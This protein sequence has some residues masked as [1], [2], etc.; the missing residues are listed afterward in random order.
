MST[1][2][3]T[4]L[5]LCF[6]DE[7]R[8]LSVTTS[9]LTFPDL[10]T[11]A[12]SVFPHLTS[13]QFSWVD[14]EGDKV[15]INSSE[16]FDEAVRVMTSENKG[17]LRFEVLAPTS[18]SSAESSEQTQAP[19][20]GA[21]S[22][23]S[24]PADNKYWNEMWNLSV[25]NDVLEL[26]NGAKCVGRNN[27]ME[28]PSKLFVRP[29]YGQL[30][31]LIM[32]Q[33]SRNAV[34]TGTPGV[35]KT[36]LRNVLVHT[37]IQ[38]HRE[39]KKSF[40]IVLDKSPGTGNALHVFTATVDTSGTMC[41]SAHT[42]TKSFFNSGREF[43]AGYPVWYLLDVSKGESSDTIALP[44]CTRTIMFTSPNEKAYKEFIKEDCVKYFMP[45]WSKDEAFRARQSLTP[46]I[47]EGEFSARW[48]KYGGVARA[49]FASDEEMRS[50]DERVM[51]AVNTLDAQTNYNNLGKTNNTSSI[52]H[53]LFYLDVLVDETDGKDSFGRSSLIVGTDH[54][55]GLVIQRLSEQ[56]EMNINNVMSDLHT[57]TA[58]SLK[59]MVLEPLALRLLCLTEEKFEVTQLGNS[60]SG[61]LKLKK[62]LSFDPMEMK[63]V[64]NNTDDAFTAAITEGLQSSSRGNILLVP[65]AGLFPVVDA[66]A[67][68][69]DGDAR[70]C[71]FL[72][73][74][75]AAK[76]AVT[77]D[78]AAAMLEQLISAAGSVTKCA[79]VYVLPN[80]RT[81]SQFKEQT[82]SG[83]KKNFRQYK[84]ALVT[85][86]TKEGA[87]ETKKRTTETKENT[88]E[89]K[90]RK[91]K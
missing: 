60:R 91:K 40:S 80:N 57:C 50:Y 43:P 64:D 47:N 19:R 38:S 11:K 62:M 8:R 75:V 87:A 88:A 61:G 27:T 69:G 41:W 2:S 71:L 13:V 67:I 44:D 83:G 5:K 26:K 22:R 45:L 90:K 1:N 28:G 53:L 86:K 52:T 9:G 14:N 70:C 29:C 4:S 7:I 34:I 6:N 82:I 54:I 30:I 63:A 51:E 33:T 32:K 66:V 68:V 46:S 25:Q 39:Q 12:M 76:H 79:L 18:T 58:G 59:G 77:G 78:G 23:S 10:M 55:K 37:L 73:V 16:E 81:F 17:C 72:Q 20:G 56:V 24:A 31:P 84:I 36:M 35:G 65:R 3:L 89:T 48:E 15:M 42:H 85:A 49:L 74:T 21:S